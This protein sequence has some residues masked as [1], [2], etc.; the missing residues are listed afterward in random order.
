[1]L[2]NPPIRTIL[3][4]EDE[5]MVRT[6]LAVALE[7]AG[8]RVIEARNG[9]EACERLD[10]GADLVLTDIIMPEMD[11]I[12]LVNHIRDRHPRIPVIGMTAGMRDLVHPLVSVLA[13]RGVDPVLLKPFDPE[14]M[15]DA[16]RRRLSQCRIPVRADG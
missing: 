6:V 2:S 5:D 3:L 8:F 4:V 9:I 14:V 7:D 15:V 16:V 10:Q 12:E 13:A 1:M 11:G